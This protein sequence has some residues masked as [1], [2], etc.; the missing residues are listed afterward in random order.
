MYYFR[1][2]G[3]CGSIGSGG[4][5]SIL[6]PS[7]SLVSLG[8]RVA[9]PILFT[10]LTLLGVLSG[11]TAGNQAP[12]ASNNNAPNTTVNS[13][14]QAASINVVATTSVLC[15]LTQRIVRSTDKPTVKLNCLVKAGQDPHTY[16]PNPADR[17]AIEDADLIFYGGYGLEPNVVR[18]ITAA[19]NAITKVAVHELAV[20]KPLQGGH[21]HDDEHDHGGGEPDQ[22]EA[23]AKETPAGTVE[24]SEAEEADP[25]VWHNAQNGIQM[26]KV[27]ETALAKADPSNAALY[28]KNAQTITDRLTKVDSW[29]KASISTIPANARKLIT[30]HDA[31]GYYAAA[32]GIPVQGA[33]QGLSTD[34]QPT[35]TQVK[36]LVDVVKVA[37]VPTIFAEK[38]V[39]PALI[40]TVAREAGV[41]VAD[42]ELL[43][44]GLG[45][46]GSGAETY[47]E[48]L[49]SNTK[50]IVTG[51]G[52][53]IT[54]LKEP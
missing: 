36:T 34:E 32:Y 12:N 29:I 54:A 28:A 25:H 47:E 9:A 1:L 18:L 4:N 30:T 21:H 7:L 10:G 53:N 8:Q 19:P 42:R 6:A 17:K 37:Q 51:L 40:Q 45:E 14:N 27:I 26:V 41:K 39:N 50:T 43:A 24:H 48:M 13:S 15:D 2:L 3:L 31:L 11:C 35:P 20:P 16:Q 52:G 23:K 49:I 5:R 22:P 44:D 38:T 46:A 33:L